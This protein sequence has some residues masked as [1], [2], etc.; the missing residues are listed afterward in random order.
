MICLDINY[1]SRIL[2]LFTFGSNQYEGFWVAVRGG[3]TVRCCK[4]LVKYVKCLP[5][6][7]QL[8][9][10]KQRPFLKIKIFMSGKTRKILE[11]SGNF[12]HDKKY[13]EP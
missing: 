4:E 1:Y 10:S 6:V 8:P 2:P 12:V 11:K 13:E 5:V 9:N 3:F 7:M